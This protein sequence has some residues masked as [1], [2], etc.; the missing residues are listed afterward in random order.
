MVCC[1]I[2]DIWV[3]LDKACRIL[4][5]LARSHSP[6]TTGTDILGS[7]GRVTGNDPVQNP[8]DLGTGMGAI[9]IDEQ[10]RQLLEQPQ[11]RCHIRKHACVHRQRTQTSTDSLMCPSRSQ[12]CGHGGQ[13][14]QQRYPAVEAVVNRDTVWGNLS[15]QTKGFCT[16]LLL[17]LCPRGQTKSKIVYIL[18]MRL[19]QT[20]HT[21]G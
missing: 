8:T 21:D 10:V 17:V 9:S 3:S 11:K 2:P 13:T 15:I 20:P 18:D 7:L 5:T 4:R 14:L 6:S 16:L 1:G 12:C 19:L